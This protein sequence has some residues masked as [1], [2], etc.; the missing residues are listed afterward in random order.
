[1]KPITLLAVD[2]E[3]TLCREDAFLLDESSVG[4]TIRLR[5]ACVIPPSDIK[6]RTQPFLHNIFTSG[7]QNP[8][9]FISYED[10]IHA[11]LSCKEPKK[12]IIVT[13]EFSEGGEFTTSFSIE[14]TLI[15][16][17]DYQSFTLLPEFPRIQHGIEEFLYQDP[18]VY[19]KYESKHTEQNWS[20]EKTPARRLIAGTSM[21]LNKVLSHYAFKNKIETFKLSP[22]GLT[23]RCHQ[24]ARFRN[25]LRRSVSF[26]NLLNLVATIEGEPIPYPL[27]RVQNIIGEEFPIHTRRH[28]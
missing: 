10:R 23:W 1:M 20:S 11:G 7:G 9:F 22:N 2:E 18:H 6:I 28:T 3:Q 17:S 8:E 25:P 15:K 13:L 26:V 5:I 24:E 27:G 19:W 4:E 16:V 12:A 14:K 21:M